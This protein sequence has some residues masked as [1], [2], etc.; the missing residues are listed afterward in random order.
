M[1]GATPFISVLSESL[2]FELGV[3]VLIVIVA[4]YA[5]GSAAEAA[6]K[7]L[8]LWHHRNTPISN[9]TIAKALEG[10]KPPRYGLHALGWLAFGGLIVWTA[11][12][13]F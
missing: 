12:P 3:R 13:I 4:A 2:W 1:N 10:S 5:L 6:Y 9:P 11:Y 8:W 7:G